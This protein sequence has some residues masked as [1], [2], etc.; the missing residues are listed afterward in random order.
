MEENKLQGGKNHKVVIN[1]RNQ[2]Q[3]FTGEFI[4]EELD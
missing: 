2:E 1:N 3:T 4:F